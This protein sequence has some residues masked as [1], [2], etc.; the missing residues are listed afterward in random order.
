MPV[1]THEVVVVMRL[2][3]YEIDRIYLY[4]YDPNV[5]RVNSS[6]SEI[7]PYSYDNNQL[8]GIYNPGDTDLMGAA[9]K[10]E[11]GT[12]NLIYQFNGSTSTEVSLS[13]I[14]TNNE[15]GKV[16]AGALLHDPIYTEVQR[17]K[18]EEDR[19]ALIYYKCD[20]SAAEIPTAA[21]TAP[22]FKG[23]LEAVD[24]LKWCDNEAKAIQEFI[25]NNPDTPIPPIERI[26]VATSYDSSVMP[27]PYKAELTRVNDRLPDLEMCI[28]VTQ[29]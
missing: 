3:N 24:T 27:N 19:Q 14:E 16:F 13:D 4:D 21:L 23:L 20:V 12:A 7:D 8:G 5:G 18:Y 17:L 2:P 28:P 11:S 25:K 10:V 29:K 26:V 15:Y 6:Q 22:T 1:I 9:E